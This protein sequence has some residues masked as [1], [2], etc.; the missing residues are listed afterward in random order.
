MKLFRILTLFAVSFFLFSQPV[1]AQ[2]EKGFWRNVLEFFYPSLR[3]PEANPYETLQ[4]PFTDESGDKPL[5]FASQNEDD[6]VAYDVAHRLS[7]DVGKWLTDVL[8]ETMTFG[9]DNYQDDLEKTAAYFD[10]NGRGLYLTFLEDSKMLRILQSN[11]F[12]IRSFVQDTP[13]LLNEGSVAG[14]YRWLF[15]V[16]VQVSY[17]DRRLEDYAEGSATTQVMTLRVQLMRSPNADEEMGVIIDQWEGTA[18][19]VVKPEE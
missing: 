9:S 7:E 17:M 2:Q 19:K 12:Y 14:Y 3:T 6:V 16:P 15:E 5:P 13:F 18:G 8:S 10:E 11:K 4:A 1:Y